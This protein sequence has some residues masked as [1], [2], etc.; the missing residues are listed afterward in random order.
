MN[1]DDQ[2]NDIGK[3]I[4]A[5]L[6]ATGE[7]VTYEKL[8]DAFS[9][10]P[11][12]IKT[13]V[14]DLSE[15]YEDRG[16]QLL[17]YDKACQLC[18]KKEYEEI[19]KDVLGIRKNGA[20]SKSCLETLA[21]IAYNQPV[22]RSYIDEVRGVDSSYAIGVLT[23]RELIKITGKL[24]VPGKPNLYATNE[25]FLRVFGL[26]SL[27]E[28]PKVSVLSVQDEESGAETNEEAEQATAES[29]DEERKQTAEISEQISIEV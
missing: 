29:A 12:Q 23:Q 14:S 28:L 11:T 24:D 6:F 8:A 27:S 4:E 10:T 15:R 5:V 22:T 20:L 17:C 26:N 9:L 1:I 21:V 3:A 16:I 18:T 25:N 7:A 13:V 2:I 19:I